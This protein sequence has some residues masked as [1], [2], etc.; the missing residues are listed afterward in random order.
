MS[1]NEIRASYVERVKAKLIPVEQCQQL[2]MWRMDNDK[3]VDEK[4]IC[5][6]LH[7]LKKDLIEAGELPCVG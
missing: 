7:L 4:T 5:E 2:F 3:D 1:F 6:Q